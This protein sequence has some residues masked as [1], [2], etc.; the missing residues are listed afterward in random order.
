MSDKSTITIKDIVNPPMVVELIFYQECKFTLLNDGVLIGG[1]KQRVIGQIIDKIPQKYIVYAGPEGGMAQVALS[2]CCALWNQF[3]KNSPETHKK[4]VIFVQAPVNPHYEKN[5]PLCLLARE[6]GADICFGTH[7]RTLKDTQT[8]AEDFVAKMN[9]KTPES[10]ILMPFGMKSDEFGIA[11]IFEDA[12]R[13]ALKDIAPPKRLWL[14]A[15]SGF[16]LDILHKIYPDTAFMVVQVGKKIWEDQLGAKDNLYIE[17]YKF[18]E[19]VPKNLLPPY[20]SIPW[21]DA[22]LWEFVMK[23][24]EDGDYI[25]NVGAIPD[26][27]IEY[28]KHIMQNIAKICPEKN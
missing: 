2:Y 7:Y 11:K 15:G 26:N 17:K 27:P 5:S 4:V 19:S 12:L 8:S 3:H 23:Y 20:K 10:A 13:E 18:T 21:Y 6:L 9:Q 16:I 1:T 14:V 28:G 22:K 24:G 25:W